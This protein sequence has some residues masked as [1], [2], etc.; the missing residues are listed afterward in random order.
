M[1]GKIITGNRALVDWFPECSTT[2]SDLLDW[3]APDRRTACNHEQGF[4]EVHE[5]PSGNLVGTA[6][7]EFVGKTEATATPVGWSWTE[8][9]AVSS[10]TGLGNPEGSSAEFVPCPGDCLGVDK[11]YL[12]TGVDSWHGSVSLQPVAM[13]SGTV[14]ESWGNWLVQFNDPRW[15]NPIEIWTSG[16]VGRCDNAIGN[17]SPGCVYGNIWEIAWLSR[18]AAPEFAD[19]VSQAQASGLP[20]APYSDTYLTK[21]DD[22]ALRQANG[23]KA[24]PSSIPRPQGKSCD[25]YPF[26]STYEGASTGGSDEARS[27]PGCEMPDPERTGPTG[28]SRCFILVGD[29]SSG[30]GQMSAFYSNERML[31]GDP[32]QVGFVE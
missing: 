4:I 28:W 6:T 2:T 20:G 19:H 7:V 3:T 8:D 32:F 29:N 30:G 10:F 27:F 12:P 14:L 16:V 5:V 31:D 22:P 18:S 9:V 17:R 15:A 21:L 24:C 23:D 25:E 26:R 11:S 13:P 1:S